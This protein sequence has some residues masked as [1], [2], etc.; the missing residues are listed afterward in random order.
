MERAGM[1]KVKVKEFVADL[2]LGVALQCF[3]S[4]IFEKRIYGLSFFTE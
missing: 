4:Q 1:P 3:Q 2:W